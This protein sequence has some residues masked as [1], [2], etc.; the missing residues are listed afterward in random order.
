MLFDQIVSAKITGQQFTAD[1]L[2]RGV[3][4]QLGGNARS[5]AERLQ[6]GKVVPATAEVAG[7]KIT[8][9]VEAEAELY[10]M[11]RELAEA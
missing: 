3:R 10:F 9:N 8:L 6:P 1:Q 5:S 2:R 7:K 4:V 11:E